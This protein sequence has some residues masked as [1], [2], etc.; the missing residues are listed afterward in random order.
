MAKTKYFHTTAIPK[1]AEQ[2]PPRGARQISLLI[3]APT[4]ARALEIYTTYHGRCSLKGFK[5]YASATEGTTSEHELS[6]DAKEGIW[7]KFLDY[8]TDEDYKEIW[9][10]PLL[11]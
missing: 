3:K 2:I 10:T 8:T 6:C 9:S 5:D 1:N 4:W 11:D 7:W